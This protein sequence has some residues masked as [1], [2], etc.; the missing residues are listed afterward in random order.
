MM[1]IPLAVIPVT[2]PLCG[3]QKMVQNI[4]FLF[5]DSLKV[6]E[7]LYSVSKKWAMKM[8]HVSDVIHSSEETTPNVP[9]KPEA[10]K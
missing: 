4:T 8:I 7:T 10:P 5:M 3:N 6:L 9:V 2:A 1:R